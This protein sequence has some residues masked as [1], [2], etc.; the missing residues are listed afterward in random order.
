MMDLHTLALFALAALA[1]IVVPGPSVGFI[2]ATTLRRG[3]SAGLRAT[4]GI[5]LGYLVHVTGAV[6]G[7]SAV[8]AASATAFTVVKVVGAAWLLWLAVRTWR[9]RTPGTVDQWGAGPVGAGDG[10]AAGSELAGAEQAAAPGGGELRAGL[11]VGALNPKTALFYL[12]FLPQFVRPDAG[13]P[14]LQ[15]LTLGLVFIGLAWA[16]DS[17]WAVGGEG[18][19]RLLPRVR[20][21]LLDRVSAGVYAALG[22]VTLTARRVA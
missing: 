4:A 18:L 19:R 21:A 1:L 6:V 17:L 12:A 16:V 2:L 3:R 11:L 8:I 22:L 9:A 15:L 13:P 14:W 20:L 5:E 7:V 10:S